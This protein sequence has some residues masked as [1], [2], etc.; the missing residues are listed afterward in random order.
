MP[1]PRGLLLS[2]TGLY[3]SVSYAAR[4]RTREMAIRSALGASRAAILWNALGN[5]V[6]IL[7]CGVILGLPLAIAA[8]RPIADLIPY[9]VNAWNPVYFIGVVIVLVATGTGAAFLPARFAANVDPALALR[10]E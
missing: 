5:A 6:A 4:L 7:G 1:S 9:G 3:S 8:I 2:L 10:Q